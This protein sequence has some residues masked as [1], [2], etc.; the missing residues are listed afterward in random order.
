MI[1]SCGTSIATHVFGKQEKEISSKINYSDT[2][3]FYNDIDNSMTRRFSYAP[4]TVEEQKEF[5][6]K[7]IALQE[8][9]IF[10]R[11]LCEGNN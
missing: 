3:D 10:L 7:L 4:E 6:L 11:V 5:D 1:K 8:T 2:Y 9:F